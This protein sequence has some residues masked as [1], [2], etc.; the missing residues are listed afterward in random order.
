[1]L[2]Q[3][4][5]ILRKDVR[6]LR[7]EIAGVLAMNVLFAVTQVLTLRTIRRWGSGGGFGTLELLLPVTWFFIIARAVQAEP[8][9][10]DRQFWISR[11][12]RRASL[13]L[14]KAIFILTF[15]NLPFLIMQSAILKLDAFPIL[16]N[17]GALLWEQLLVTVVITLPALVLAAM[18]A[19]MIQFVVGAVLLGVLTVNPFTT[20]QA[21]GAVGWLARSALA[22]LTMAAGLLILWLQYHVRKTIVSLG[23]AASGILL[24]VLLIIFAPWAS[25]FP[26]QSQLA[27]PLRSSVRVELRPLDN[28]VSRG[29][30]PK[31]YSYLSI[32]LRITGTPGNTLLRCEGADITITAPSGIIW[33]SRTAF[34]LP[35]RQ[36]PDGCVTERVMGRAYLLAHRDEPLHIHG[37]L[38]LTIF[39]N[40]RS[41]DLSMEAPTAV[42][43]VGQCLVLPGE[44]APAGEIDV[45]YFLC[46]AALRWPRI[47]VTGLAKDG[48]AS[49]TFGTVRSYS[50]FPADYRLSPVETRSS[51]V[52]S[53]E[54]I[55]ITTQEPLA[56]FRSEFDATN[57]RFGDLE[58]L[59]ETY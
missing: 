39:G 33:N 53:P 27:E 38:S 29:I 48:A 21:L 15:V 20:L 7:F 2:K 54:T 42:P 16:S 26:I 10:G 47:L 12:Y 37:T 19:N 8:I 57:I 6:H 3:A 40:P 5:H 17:A 23:V 9:P 46:M 11:P 18:T 50:P 13:L 45:R 58:T 30:M 41:T 28:S 22:V 35:F 49:D 51:F 14:A 52:A 43:G 32:P 55:T 56:H 34:S 31:G 25:A 36:T 1:M 4:L 24:G 44:P 59:S